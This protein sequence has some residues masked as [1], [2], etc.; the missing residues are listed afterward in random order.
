MILD[1]ETDIVDVCK[2]LILIITNYIVV[3]LRQSF[4]NW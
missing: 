4:I 2:Q 3:S 1:K